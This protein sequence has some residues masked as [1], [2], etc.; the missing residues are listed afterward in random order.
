M[1]GFALLDEALASLSAGDCRRPETA[2]K[3]LWSLLTSCDRAGD[4]HG[5]LQKTSALPDRPSGRLVNWSCRGESM[6]TPM[7]M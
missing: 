4:T 3:S 6:L 2:G 5:E 7:C 1:E